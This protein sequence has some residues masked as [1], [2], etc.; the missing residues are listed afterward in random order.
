MGDS[1]WGDGDEVSTVLRSRI[2]PTPSPEV[3]FR[4]VVVEGP[5][6]G[7]AHS[8]S[9]SEA[10]R[11]LV[12]QS[13]V[14]HVR[15]SD[16]EVSRRHLALELA[17]GRVHLSDLRS[18]NGTTVDGV[19]VIE[20]VLDGGETIRL[21]STS[22]RLERLAAAPT[23]SIPNVGNFGRVVGA[24]TEM[25][26]IYPLCQ[27]LAASM[28]PVVI[29][30]ETG[31]G[32]EL[33]AEALHEAG[34][35]AAGP[36]VVFDCTAVPPNLVESELF[37]HER[38]AFT[39]AVGPRKGLF[40]QADGGTL[41][42]DEIGDLE[43]ALQPKL[44]RAL[45]RSEI[46]RLGGDR[47]LR[48]DVRVLAA[49]RRDLDQAVQEGRFRDDLF[50]RLAVTRIELPPLRARR[51]D[52]P[53]LARHF[54]LE[55]GGDPQGPPPEL[56]RR[57]RDDPWPGNVR[58]LRNAVARALALGA[59]DADGAAGFA[60]A[61]PHADLVD[62]VL[63]LDLPLSRARQHVVLE[64]ERRYVER[65]LARHGGN[66]QRAAAEAGVA[67]RYFRILRSKTTR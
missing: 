47:P 42:I 29:E 20:A 8:I 63:A 9:G 24:S 67:R 44:L 19:T 66:V 4:L 62:R 31:T 2:D 41:L 65:A 13:P 43:P 14:C 5:D 40:E 34:P 46:R 51:G 22:F 21:G 7:A 1:V 57:F 50:H 64:F 16:R 53:I 37:G 15:L 30:G 18:T 45:E 27:R 58:G 10:S 36:F 28:V 25:R 39:G 17:G 60:A 12:G 23:P 59:L 52:V 38:G 48:V 61:E 49:T 56:L 3:S 26:R 35:R 6:A 32:K 33:L 54:W 55:M 11:V